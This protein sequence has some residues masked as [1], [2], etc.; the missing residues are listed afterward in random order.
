MMIDYYYY[1]GYSIDNRIRYDSSSGGVGATIIKYLIESNIFGTSITFDF[2][3]SQCQYLPRLIYD[4]SEYNNC[5]SIYQ[6][7]D[8]I[9]FIKENISSIR[10]GIIITCMPCQVKPIKAVLNKAG[11]RYFIISLCCS[12]QTTKQGTWFYYKLLGIKKADVECIDIGEGDGRQVFK[13]HCEMER[14]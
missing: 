14:W 6:D 7:I 11:I 9:N 1:I 10:N 5:G 4:F 3:K 13:L 12:G 8:I 2:N